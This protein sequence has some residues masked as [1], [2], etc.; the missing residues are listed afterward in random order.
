[1]QIWW[2]IIFVFVGL[3]PQEPVPTDTIIDNFVGFI[4]GMTIATVLGRPIWP[5]LPQTVMRDNLL[6]VFRHISA[7][8]N[9]Q[10][11]RE[12]I[13]NQLAILP[14]EAFQASRQIRFAGFTAQEKARFTALIRSLQ[15]LLTRTTVLASSRHTLPGIMESLVQPRLQAEPEFKPNDD[16]AECL[17]QADCRDQLLSLNG[18]LSEMNEA[19]EIIRR[20]GMS[21]GQHFEASVYRLELIEHYRTTAEAFEACRRLIATLKTHRYL[22]HCGL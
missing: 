5:V 18:A 7:L 2:L 6:A 13:Q 10:P 21:N 22:D 3:N 20:A 16:F 11:H 19:H 14:A 4:T 9:G 12:K 1:M 15:N 8:L 17:R